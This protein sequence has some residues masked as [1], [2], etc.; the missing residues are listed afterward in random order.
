MTIIKVFYMSDKEIDPKVQLHIKE[1]HEK[2]RKDSDQK[3]AI[4][5]VERVV[6][7]LVGAI[8]MGAVVAWLALIIK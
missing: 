4:K 2:L 5:L 7:G 1:E 8:L 6:F 3:Y